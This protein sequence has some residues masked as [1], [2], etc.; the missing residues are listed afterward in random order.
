MIDLVLADEDDI[1]RRD[2]DLLRGCPGAHLHVQHLATAGAV[3][4][5]R[6]AR[7][8]GLAASAE[9]TPHHL[10]LT[11]EAVAAHGSAA[12]MAPPLPTVAGRDA[13]RRALVE[14]V[15]S[16][17]ASDHAPHPASAKARPLPLTPNGIIGLE[18]TL[19]VL[20]R[21]LVHELGVPL[22]TV[23][24]A[25]SCN[26]ARLLG[27]DAGDLSIGRPADVTVLDPDAGVTIDASRFRSRSRNT[28]FDGY[29][30]RGRIHAVLAGGRRIL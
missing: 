4:L 3:E 7:A 22:A 15:I 30:G 2:L 29:A 23:I 19:P 1:V 6:A 26:P 28:P 25:L 9:V 16:I 24:A 17:I 13:L 14:G 10:A 18:T 21:V 27:L 20:L 12:K 5:L 11:D 8:Q